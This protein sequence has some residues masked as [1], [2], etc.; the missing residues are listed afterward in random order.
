[1]LSDFCVEDRAQSCLVGK[2]AVLVTFAAKSYRALGRRSVNNFLFA[3]RR[4]GSFFFLDKKETKNQGLDLMSD[5]LAIALGAAP[6]VPD[7]GPGIA[8]C[9]VLWW[10]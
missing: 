2:P 9:L 6:Q 7:E 8:R 4:N 3:H 5:K 10:L 1:M